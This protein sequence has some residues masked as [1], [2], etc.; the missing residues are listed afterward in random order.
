MYVGTFNKI[1]HFT[2]D[3]INKIILGK[4]KSRKSLGLRDRTGNSTP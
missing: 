2:L 3:D 1:N 4:L